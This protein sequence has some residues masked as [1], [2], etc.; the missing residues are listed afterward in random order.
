MVAVL[1]RPTVVPLW[2]TTVANRTDPGG[3]KKAD[4]WVLSEKP[5]ADFF[6]WIDGYQS[7]W[8]AWIDERFFDGTGGPD[9]LDLNPGGVVRSLDEFRVETAGVLR[10]FAVIADVVERYSVS[11]KGTVVQTLKEA[12]SEVGTIITQG[13]AAGIQTKYRNSAGL[14]RSDMQHDPVNGGF[15]WFASTTA[16]KGPELLRL[17]EADGVVVSRAT[18]GVALKVDGTGTATF[19]V[20]FDGS[21]MVELNNAGNGGIRISEPVGIQKD[22]GALIV[23]DVLETC[24]VFNS[25]PAEF[26]AFAD[27]VTFDTEWTLRASPSVSGLAQW[28]IT[29][30][31]SPTGWHFVN[32]LG[33]RT[34]VKIGGGQN[35]SLME[36]N[37]DQGDYDLAVHTVGQ[38]NAFFVNAS[39]N[40]VSVNVLLRTKND[41]S[42]ELGGPDITITDNFGDLEIACDDSI[43]IEYDSGA[44]AQQLDFKRGITTAA[45]F[46]G[47]SDFQTF[48]DVLIEPNATLWFDGATQSA[49]I[50]LDDTGPTD[51]LNIVVSDGNV[52]LDVNPNATGLSSNFVILL[53]G[54]TAAS[55]LVGSTSGEKTLRLSS[56]RFNSGADTAGPGPGGTTLIGTTLT[57][58]EANYIRVPGSATIADIVTTDWA[59]GAVIYIRNSSTGNVVINQTGNITNGAGTSVT[60]GADDMATLVLDAVASEWFVVA[61]NT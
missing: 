25:G 32:S 7:D 27:G 17:N 51:Q 39:A 1:T 55:F 12:V 4:G 5:P 10:P 37:A 43:V 9:E 45:S 31:A 30:Q 41:G 61:V 58:A 47:T 53:E 11:D 3:V 16:S 21:D 2:S 24:R 38:L 19:E 15:Q 29:N 33:L 26:L 14:F 48:F 22:P 40:R 28:D 57:I 18:N 23:L 13:L 50:S 34:P 52:V 8:L 20:N 49:G 6:N 44:T 46:T 36:I 42:I 56:T 54:S 60:L 59:D 35:G